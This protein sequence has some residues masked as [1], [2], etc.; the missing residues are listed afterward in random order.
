M[1]LPVGGRLEK[2]PLVIPAGLSAARVAR[3]TVVARGD[4]RVA[5]VAWRLAQDRYFPGYRELSIPLVPDGREHAYE[6]EIGR[7]PY[8][9]GEVAAL[10]LSVSGGTAE[11]VALRGRS[12]G[13]PY[14]LIC[15]AG[16]CMPA[17]LGLRSLVFDLPEGVAGG[18]R[19]EAR[20]G[21][22][23]EFDRAGVVVTYRGFIERG[24]RRRPW[25]EATESGDAER[26]ARWRR[27]RGELPA[28]GGRLVLEVEARRGG[29]RLPE[30]VGVWGD[31]VLV[32]GGRRAGPHLVIVMIDTLRADVVGAYGD[33]TGLTPR[34]DELAGQG[35]RF[36][37][38][39]APA[40]WTLP[41][42][43]TLLTGLEPQTHGAG[44]RFGEY[45]PTG[46][47]GGART[48]A[49]TLREAGFYSLGVYHNIYVNPAFG[50]HQGFDEYVSLE[51]RAP[52]LVEEALG[53]LARYRDDRR[54]FLY[55]HLFDPHN[56]YEP[57]REDCERVARRFL[58]GYA[59]P[60]GCAADRR[61]EKSIPPRRD[62]RWHEALYRAEVAATDRA[63][64]RFLAGLEE[65]GLAGD[66]VL[67]V[68]SDHGEEFWTRVEQE[69][70]GGYQVNADHG[71]THY[72][73][74]LRVPGILRAPGLAPAVVERPVRMADLFPTLLGLLGVEAPPSQGIDLAPA[75]AGRP[76]PRA[77]LVADAIL[78]GPERWAVRRGPWKLIVPRQPQGDGARPPAPALPLELYNL[79]DDP[80][81][82]VN[83]AAAEPGTAA[84]LRALGE[85]EL[86]ARAAAR[87]RFLAGDEALGATYLEWNQITKLRSLG[88][89]R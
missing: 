76:Q 32:T 10:R 85:R 66:T 33:R 22:V 52:V 75:L 21:L 5:T 47:P 88:Y 24:G 2:Q 78:H 81:E 73:E 41:S 89:L 31:P 42:V 51:E 68:V 15:L 72:Q 7:Q 74:L 37:D 38:L 20:L 6:V 64:G 43:A 30:G 34:L 46:L 16:E 80:G 70:A 56:P 69:R 60:L 14:K 77:P 36:D 4:A 49:E 39:S 45:A 58:P 53:R 3:L 9:T 19:F 61:P 87:R 48:L 84:A 1:E 71:H 57:P 28:G 62:R 18:T 79:A 54:L 50:L 35:V 55:L 26:R 40:P 23:P 67:L 12:G 59:G 83:R 82:T 25:F 29:R 86:A 13:D 17:L 44:R 65:L 11:L 27:V 8:W 63:A